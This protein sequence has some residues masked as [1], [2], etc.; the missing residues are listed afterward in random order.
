MI[1]E[2]KQSYFLNQSVCNEI[3]PTVRICTAGAIYKIE[4]TQ[5]NRLFAAIKVV[6]FCPESFEETFRRHNSVFFVNFACGNTSNHSVRQ[7]LQA[8]VLWLTFLRLIERFEYMIHFAFDFC[9]EIFCHTGVV[10][11]QLCRTIRQLKLSLF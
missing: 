3:T 10:I 5:I 4:F 7:F 1:C 6:D 8:I 9:S 11:G 2:G